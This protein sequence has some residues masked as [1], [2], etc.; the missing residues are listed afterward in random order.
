[1]WGESPWLRGTLPGMPGP[2]L[3]TESW[4]WGETARVRVPGPSLL[5]S[6]PLT[7]TRDTSTSP[8]C[9]HQY[10]FHYHNFSY[11]LW[12]AEKTRYSDPRGY[13]VHD[14]V[15]GWFYPL[16]HG[17][18]SHYSLRASLTRTLTYDTNSN[19][20]KLIFKKQISFIRHQLAVLLT[21]QNQRVVL[22]VLV[23][24]FLSSETFYGEQK[25]MHRKFWVIL[26]KFILGGSK[27]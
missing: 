24:M 26:C 27:Q 23:W 19:D 10:Y 21:S 6:G 18:V 9:H 20:M 25:A 17:L 12:N 5:S 13:S 8:S 22:G 4:D 16:R 15:L 2:S 1:M 14:W 3:L 11:N 7:S